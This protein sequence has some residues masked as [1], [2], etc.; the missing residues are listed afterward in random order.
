VAL[1]DWATKTSTVAAGLIWVFALFACVVVH[2][3]AHCLVAKSRGANATEILLIPFGGFSRI[4]DLTAEPRNERDIAAAGPLASIALGIAFLT[5][6]F[7]LGS[8][9]WPPTMFV[10][11]W[12]VRLGWLNL[13]L[14]GFN[15]IPALPLDGGRMLRAGLTIRHNHLEATIR[16]AKIARYAA[17]G[18][19]MAAFFSYDYMLVLVAF[20]IVMAAKQE[21]DEAHA[22]ASPAQP[23]PDPSPPD[24]LESEH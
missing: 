12:W 20:F 15:L 14:A 13:A 10:G 3:L 21:V 22:A 9:V 19:F 8:K 24:H 6:A 5:V 1:A 17:M 2:E 7:A 4:D 23:L 11:S 18:M 16:A